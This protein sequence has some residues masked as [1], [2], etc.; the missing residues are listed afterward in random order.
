MSSV[1][2]RKLERLGEG[3]REKEQEREGARA[4]ERV[5]GEQEWA[6]EVRVREH[7]RKCVSERERAK[8]WAR[9]G[10]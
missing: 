3:A 5:T 1:C 8:E 9:Y 6:R 10:R 4:R 2:I 7:K